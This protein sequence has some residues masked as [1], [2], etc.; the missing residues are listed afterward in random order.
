MMVT[1][2]RMLESQGDSPTD[3][4]HAD[5]CSGW[6]GEW[7]PTGDE[8]D[9]VRCRASMV[10]ALR[11][12]GQNMEDKQR[13]QLEVL[14][15]RFEASGDGPWEAADELYEQVGRLFVE[16]GYTV[17]FGGAMSPFIEVY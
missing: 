1:K 3:C 9:E 5:A 8:Q 17:Y 6:G 4:Y 11:S 13:R 7:D 2:G 12:A 14:V 15:D 16:S 10:D